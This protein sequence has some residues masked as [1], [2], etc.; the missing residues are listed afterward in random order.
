MSIMFRARS[1]LLATVR[2]DLERRHAFAAE[3]VGFLVCSA[4]ASRAAV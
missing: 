2:H 4:A 3:R 1:D